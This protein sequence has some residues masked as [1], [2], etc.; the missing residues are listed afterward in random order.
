VTHIFKRVAP[1][2]QSLTFEQFKEAI[3]KMFV[4]SNQNRAR[5]L[6]KR[7]KD[8]IKHGWTEDQIEQAKL[9]VR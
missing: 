8:P 9:E 5:D 4:E 3:E 7:L 6:K 1:G 2:N